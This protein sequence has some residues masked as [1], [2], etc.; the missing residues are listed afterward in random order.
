M[1]QIIPAFIQPGLIIL[2]DHCGDGERRDKAHG[3]IIP[4]LQVLSSET[5]A[6]RDIVRV[7]PGCS[8]DPAVDLFHD[9]GCPLISV[10]DKVSSHTPG[11]A[12]G[13]V[14]INAVVAGFKVVGA[15]R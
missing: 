7:I 13:I 3:L 15:G 5:I 6:G 9:A 11:H 14:I 8:P 12:A 10:D 1:D 4:V 2:T